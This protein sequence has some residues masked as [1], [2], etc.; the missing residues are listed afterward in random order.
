MRKRQLL[1]RSNSVKLTKW[2]IDSYECERILVDDLASHFPE[3]EIE[4][5]NNNTFYK[6][7]SLEDGSPNSTSIS[8]SSLDNFTTQ[9]Q[10]RSSN[11]PINTINLKTVTVSGPQV[12][13]I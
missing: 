10:H 13:L 11:I 4:E 3:L 7:S 8:S 5:I 6:E 2:R 1:L 9:Y 12:Q